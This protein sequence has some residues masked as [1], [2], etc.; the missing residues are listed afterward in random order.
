MR[1]FHGTEVL[2]DSVP[3]LFFGEGF[4][5]RKISVSDLH[6]PGNCRS[7]RVIKVCFTPMDSG[8]RNPA[9]V[10]FGTTASG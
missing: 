2:Y 6:F 1:Q 5:S 10:E 7:K 9:A 3:I 8:N 4:V